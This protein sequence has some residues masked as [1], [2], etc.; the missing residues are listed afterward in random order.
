MRLRVPH[1]PVQVHE[2]V[3]NPQ[4]LQSRLGRKTRHARPQAE[5]V[6]KV[7]ARIGKQAGI[8]VEAGNPTAGIEPKYASAHDLRRSCADR[9]RVAGVP[10]LVI[11]RVLRHTSWDTTRRHYAPGDVQSD[12]RVLQNV[13]NLTG[14]IQAPKNS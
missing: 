4:S 14:E 13:L 10:P 11:C 8:V 2:D 7:F 1:K 6:G 9:L 5:W 12:A 3:F